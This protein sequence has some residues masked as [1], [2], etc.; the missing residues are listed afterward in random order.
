MPPSI[1]KRN[2]DRFQVTNCN[3][4]LESKGLFG[5]F[6]NQMH[7]ASL[8]NLSATGIQVVSYDMLKIKKQY[9]V[10]IYSAA[11][12][13]PISTKGRVIW[14]K[15]YDGN[16]LKQYYRI[17]LEFSYFKGHAMEQIQELE[18]NPRLRAVKRE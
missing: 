16:D 11:F 3:V 5:R 7:C 6:G 12:R 1:G 9:D 2:K 10:T 8:V 17:G 13:Q 4:R 15:P 18:D 14:L